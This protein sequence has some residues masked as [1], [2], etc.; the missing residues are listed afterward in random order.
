MF[1]LPIRVTESLIALAVIGIILAGLYFLIDGLRQ[2]AREEGKAET[3]AAYQAQEAKARDQAD[4]AAAA[5][6]DAAAQARLPGADL[7][8]RQFWCRDCPEAK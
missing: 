6:Q 4:A 3:V 5:A 2:S 1:P 8:L 7:R